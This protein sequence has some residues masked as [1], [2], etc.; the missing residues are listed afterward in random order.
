MGPGEKLN[1]S[2]DSQFWHLPRPRVGAGAG[3]C[4]GAVAG[5]AAC[6]LC[7]FSIYICRCH[8]K[9]YSKGVVPKFL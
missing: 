3:A 2:K 4:A 6:C 9:K 5:A 1:E 7:I 8:S